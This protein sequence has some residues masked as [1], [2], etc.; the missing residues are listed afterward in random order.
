MEQI[1]SLNVKTIMKRKIL[2]Y[3]FIFI[4]NFLT[5]QNFSISG[6]F[7]DSTNN[8][9]LE[10][11]SVMAL[12]SA[13]SV[14]I[15]FARTDKSGAFELKNVLSKNVILMATSPGYADYLDKVEIQNNQLDLG[16]M[17]MIQMSQLIEA[18]F[19]KAQRGKMKIKGD[20]LIYLADSFKTKANAT[21]E[22]LLKKLPG[23]QVNRNGEITAQGKKVQ[24]VL[25]DGE[26]FFGDDPT[27]ATRNL[28]ANNV[29]EVKVY[30]AQ[31][32][33]AKRTGDNTASK[34]KTLDIRLNEDSKKG[35]FGKT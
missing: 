12:N 3:I 22:D 9:N 34:V 24:R 33:E 25:V 31:S 4:A 2:F 29:K 6:R 8:L 30:D 1:R 28:D 27:I 18:V 13:D 35:Y 21:V 16:N 15:G 23:L 26:E 10:N 5:A 19:I 20:T 11:V 32:D 17:N 14:L 7:I